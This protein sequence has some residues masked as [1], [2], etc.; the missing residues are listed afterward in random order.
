MYKTRGFIIILFLLFVVLIGSVLMT[1]TTIEAAASFEKAKQKFRLFKCDAEIDEFE[2][3][4][5]IDL[6]RKF[7]IMGSNMPFE[8]ALMGMIAMMVVLVFILIF[9][10]FV[11]C[12]KVNFT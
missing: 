7:I 6:E 5:Q 9:Y 4:T 8:E 11:P 1:G 10:C 3:K 12:Y 2:Q